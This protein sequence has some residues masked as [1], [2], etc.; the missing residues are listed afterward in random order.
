MSG[1]VTVVITIRN[2]ARGCAETLDSRRLN[3]Y[4]ASS[5]VWIRAIWEMSA[6]HTS[7]RVGTPVARGH[8]AGFL[9][10]NVQ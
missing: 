1:R 7:R 4:H 6:K 9:W 10:R 8:V 3:S 2:D 5:F